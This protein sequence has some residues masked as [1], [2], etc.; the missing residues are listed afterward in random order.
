MKH[1]HLT[2]ICHARTDAQR[3][4]RFHLG[5]D[6]VLPLDPPTMGLDAARV[7]IAPELR[8]R[9]TAEALGLVGP[10]DS[11]L[12]DC[13][14]G[15]WQGLSIKQ[16]EQQDPAGLGLWLGSPDAAPHGGE[17]VSQ[18]CAR[19]AQ[20]LSELPRQGEWRAVTHP[21]V[22]RAALLHV[23]EAPLES[24]HQIDVLPLSQVHFSHYGRWRLRID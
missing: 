5:E 22:I 1:T 20:W 8:T 21:M 4:G 10:L 15:R 7:L 18:L 9:Q 14:F 19:V 24:F 23:L 17:S 16:L 6:P 11:A 3:I 2:L 12:R 13:D